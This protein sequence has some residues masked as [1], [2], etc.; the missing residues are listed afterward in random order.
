MNKIIDDEFWDTV[1]GGI[2]FL[3]EEARKRLKKTDGENK[4]VGMV[5]FSKENVVPETDEHFDGVLIPYEIFQELTGLS[6]FD[7][8]EL[9]ES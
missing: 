7:R 2:G 8:F 1:N 4:V 9:E 3:L 6:F 5:F